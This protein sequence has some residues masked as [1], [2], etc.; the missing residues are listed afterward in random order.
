MATPTPAEMEVTR[1]L[2]ELLESHVIPDP[3][4]AEEHRELINLRMRQM[5]ELLPGVNKLFDG[6][7]V[8]MAG[9]VLSQTKVGE[10]DE[11][12]INAVIK[13]P[14][15]ESQISLNY[16]RSSPGYAS[17]EVLNELVDNL[18]EVNIFTQLDEKYHISGKKI[19]LLLLNAISNELNALNT[20]GGGTGGL[21][22]TNRFE[23]QMF[24]NFLMYKTEEGWASAIQPLNFNVDLAACIQLPMHALKEHPTI[25]QSLKKIRN[26]FPNLEIENVV[27]LVPKTSPRFYKE[28]NIDYANYDYESK[29]DRKS[30]WVLGLGGVENMILQHFETPTNCLMLLKYFIKNHE[31]LPLWSYYLK[32]LVV[33]MV[34]DNPDRNFWSHSNLFQ[35]FKGC[36]ERLHRAV[37]LTDLFDTFDNR[38]RLLQLKIF[39]DREL[40][41]EVE[42][43]ELGW[44][45]EAE[46][47]LRDTTRKFITAETYKIM[48]L[49]LQEIVKSLNNSDPHSPKSAIHILEE[50]VFKV[51]RFS[52]LWNRTEISLLDRL[53]EE[54]DSRSTL[55]ESKVELISSNRNSGGS[56]STDTNLFSWLTLVAKPEIRERWNIN[57]QWIRFTNVTEEWQNFMEKVSASGFKETM[58]VFKSFLYEEDC[59][60]SDCTWCGSTFSN[61]NHIFWKCEHAQC[62]WDEYC[63]NKNWNTEYRNWCSN[64]EEFAQ[65]LLHDQKLD[66]C[67]RENNQLIVK[68]QHRQ[69]LL[70]MAKAYLVICQRVGTTPLFAEHYCQCNANQQH[71]TTGEHSG[72]I[73]NK[74]LDCPINQWTFG[75]PLPAP[76]GET[77]SEYSSNQPQATLHV[78]ATM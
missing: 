62:F 63:S 54:P 44:L 76:K 65:F 27:R 7:K 20:M 48:T 55:D 59:P 1:W 35:A 47:M 26:I 17:V 51:K 5:E 64:R 72:M 33:Q 36:L 22:Q 71:K 28:H 10:S 21:K 45:Q 66:L 41:D 42:R 77:S 15:D 34:I 37:L 3:R 32:T 50:E 73:N 24:R 43:G 9:S 58:I 31:D 29:E 16:E 13:I 23:C 11:F 14:F 61:N 69:H 8:E 38:L 75:C 4:V 49:K 40:G 78:W 57:S 30:D 2:E 25:V 60:E 52:R 12:D 6:I 67:Q 19:T 18:E 53:C 70:A 46:E 68:L 74:R 56:S 39:D